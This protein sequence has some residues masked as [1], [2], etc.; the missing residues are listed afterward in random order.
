M[1]TYL[2]QYVTSRDPRVLK[3]LADNRA[4]LEDF[5]RRVSA[6]TSD[7][8][9]DGRVFIHSS[10]GTVFVTRLP[11]VPDGH[12]RWTK[13]ES[14]R[15]YRT[16]AEWAARMADLRVQVAPL[17]G[18]PDV[19]ECPILDGGYG[20]LW[21]APA[22]GAI[23]HEGAAYVDLGSRARP[24]HPS[25]GVDETVWTEIRASELH[26]ASEAAERAQGEGR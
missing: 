15:P 13:G 17:P 16:N 14:R 2:P 18:L 9:V 12:G 1:D 4:A 19:V 7:L 26:A 3:T 5:R 11:E 21:A 8:G 25:D 22:S 24:A 23:E 10:L 20:S 6:F